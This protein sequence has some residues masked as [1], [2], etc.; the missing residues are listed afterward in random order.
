[1]HADH[2]YIE[3]LRHNDQR[4][5]HDIYKQYAHH[6]LR[7]VTQHNGTAD[8]AQDVFQEAVLA[9]YDK[10]QNPD[11][12]LTCPIGAILH[13]IYSRKWID[14][15]RQKKRESVVRLEEDLR[16][17]TEITPDVLTLAEETLAEAADQQRLARAFEQ[18]SELCR[19]LLS[20]L[21]EGI[22][23]TDT[24]NKLELNSV[25]TLYRRKNACIE[26][27]RTLYSEG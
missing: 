5:I 2:Q 11:F 27:W 13:V 26:R 7:W 19:Q 20:M 18:I 8:D 25:N 22:S 4:L 16:Y 15:L 10:A 3:A 17:T 12:V 1:M 14:R 6:A 24:A 9:L 21:S 23:A